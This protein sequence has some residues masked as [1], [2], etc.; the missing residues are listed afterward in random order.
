MTRDL[1]LVK[2]PYLQRVADLQALIDAAVAEIP[3][4]GACV[5]SWNDYI[6]DFHAGLPLLRSPTVAIDFR[7]LERA[8]MSLVEA[9][10]LKPL[11]GNLAQDNHILGAQLTG[12]RDSPRKA[13]AWLLDNDSFIPTNPGLLRFLGW[14]IL[15]RYLCPVVEA[16]SAWR[17]EERWLR[18]YCPTC[19]A[20]AAMAQ[21][22]GTDPGRFRFLFCGCCR[23]VW[24]YRRTGCPFCQSADDHR[25]AVLAIEGE[26][27]L[28]IDYCEACRGYIKTYEGQRSESVLLA[29]WTS[30]HLDVI[31]HDRGFTGMR[32]RYTNFELLQRGWISRF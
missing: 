10:A 19:G 15:A 7:D 4:P 6:S 18:S 3:I 14:T 28:R 5:P 30:L 12:D 8:L 25:L 27:G 11:P 20:L 22:V 26:A 21:L 29:D 24:R 17:D 2:H 13:L 32:S 9:L 1:W 16:F 31:A 23:S